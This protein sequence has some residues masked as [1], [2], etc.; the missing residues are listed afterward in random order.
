V[1]VSLYLSITYLQ[2]LDALL[3]P[4]LSLPSLSSQYLTSQT[5]ALLSALLRAP[6]LTLPA[7]SILST[8]LTYS[9]SHHTFA[10]SWL[11]AVE[12]T[13]VA[14]ARAD[15]NPCAKALPG[16]WEA[17]WTWLESEDVG[18][19]KAAESALC[20]MV[21]YCLTD[22]D[23]RKAAEA[24]GSIGTDS[25]RKKA[26]KIPA[27]DG[28]K[29]T[30]VGSIVLRLDTSLHSVAF[31]K[32]TPALL[33]IL[34]ALISRLRL[35]TSSSDSERRVTAAEVLVPDLIE[36]VG[37]LHIA[38][39]FE[40]REK[41]DEVLGMAIRVLGPQIFL[42][43]LP[44]NITPEY[45]PFSSAILLNQVDTHNLIQISREAAPCPRSCFPSPAART[46][47]HQHVAE[48]LY[49]LLRSAL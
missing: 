41:A 4:L 47:H 26:G 49:H 16:I 31:A 21:R 40:Y 39:G 29:G 37:S 27:N 44:L 8:L 38:R 18:C 7:Q 33:S 12:N 23:L 24:V 22:A 36:Y 10:T 20:A 14:F 17:S 2:H 45:A 43:I 9:P 11:D 25:G 32:A 1:R 30:V 35:S 3:Q 13:M 42:G 48:A 34:S 15:A 5:Y 28:L 46:Q 6:T 19:R